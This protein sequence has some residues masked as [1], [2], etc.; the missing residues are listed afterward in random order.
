MCCGES[1]GERSASSLGAD[2]VSVCLQAEQLLGMKADELAEV[3]DSGE[4]FME[5]KTLQV[6]VDIGYPDGCA[7]SRRQLLIARASHTNC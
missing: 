2:V 3:R 4:A 7:T 6:A 5:I 1:Y